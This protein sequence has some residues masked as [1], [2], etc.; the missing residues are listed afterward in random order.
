MHFSKSPVVCSLELLCPDPEPTVKSSISAD[1]LIAVI[2]ETTQRAIIHLVF[3]VC[4]FVC[5]FKSFKY[6][7]HV[8]N[9]GSVQTP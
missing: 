1:M 5:L 8:R 7:Y 9:P 4:L 3:F 2:L 6:A